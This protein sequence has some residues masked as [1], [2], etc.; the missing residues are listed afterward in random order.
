[1][2]EHTVGRSIR[3]L[4]LPLGLALFVLG[5]AHR[6]PAIRTELSGQVTE[7]VMMKRHWLKVARAASPVVIMVV[8]L[9]ASA[10]SADAQIVQVTRADARHSIGFNLGY[11][12]VKGEDGRDEDDT[13]LAN[14]FATDP[15]LFEI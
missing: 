9:A 14:L 6:Y 12:S 8:M 11:F 13:I 4:F 3:G 2:T 10:S 7:I 15:L 5:R 1:M